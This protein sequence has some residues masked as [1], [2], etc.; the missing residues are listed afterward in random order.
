MRSKP[1]SIAY[2]LLVFVIVFIVALPLGAI[3]MLFWL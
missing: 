2:P 1:G 3:Q